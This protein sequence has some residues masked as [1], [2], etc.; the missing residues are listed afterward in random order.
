VL[1]KCKRVFENI[2]HLFVKEFVGSFKT[3]KCAI[4]MQETAILSFKKLKKIG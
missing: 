3:L 4:I 2:H 1:D